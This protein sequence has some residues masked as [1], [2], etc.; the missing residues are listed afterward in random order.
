MELNIGF[1]NT[2]QGIRFTL[3]EEARREVINRL[4]KLNSEYYN[5]EVKQGRHDK[6][7]S[8]ASSTKRS[9]KSNV[10][11]EDDMNLFDFANNNK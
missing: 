9:K 1:H 8:M 11:E 10:N 4:L 2:K 6:V 3:S 7:K 5:E